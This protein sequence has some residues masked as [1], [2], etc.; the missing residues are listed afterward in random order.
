MV[1]LL[2]GLCVPEAPEEGTTCPAAHYAI[3]EC[4][5]KDIIT[6]KTGLYS[7]TTQDKSDKLKG[8]SQQC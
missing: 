2:T 1:C 8:Q 3:L 6:Y 5:P 4:L 7:P